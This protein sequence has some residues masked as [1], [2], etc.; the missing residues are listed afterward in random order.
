MID[1]DKLKHLGPVADAWAVDQ[2]CLDAK[3]GDIRSK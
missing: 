2:E 3:R 1:P